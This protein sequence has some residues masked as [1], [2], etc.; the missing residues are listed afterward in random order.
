MANL[1]KSKI[2]EGYFSTSKNIFTIEKP[3]FIELTKYPNGV[4]K[5]IEI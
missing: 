2:S 3:T 1:N 5:I 4:W